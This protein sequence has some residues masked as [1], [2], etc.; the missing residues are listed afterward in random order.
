MKLLVG[1]EPP[2]RDDASFHLLSPAGG[3]T[4]SH[5]KALLCCDIPRRTLGP[6][7]S[8]VPGHALWDAWSLGMATESRLGRWDVDVRG[9]GVGRD[10]RGCRA[11]A[12]SRGTGFPS[13]EGPEA[14]PLRE[15]GSGGQHLTTA[16]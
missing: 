12:D 15:G 1:T 9:A 4:L 13:E 2:P 5:D 14:F 16:P 3:V 11:S 7:D 8:W 10:L 6:G